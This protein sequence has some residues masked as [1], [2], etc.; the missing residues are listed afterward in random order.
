MENSWGS[1]H[2]CAAVHWNPVEIGL[3]LLASAASVLTRT[4]CSWIRPLWLASPW[5]TATHT[6]THSF[7]AHQLYAHSLV[8]SV[9]GSCSG[10]ST[11]EV[12]P[13]A[14]CWWPPTGQTYPPRSTPPMKTQWMKQLCFSQVTPR[15]R[16]FTISW[17]S[18]TFVFKHKCYRTARISTSP[19][20]VTEFVWLSNQKP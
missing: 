20:N 19:I 1:C 17:I 9:P 8:L 6:H 11:S 14:P 16:T 10:Q 2:C 18:I 12:N 7:Q 3:V 5:R 4:R 13:L 15:C